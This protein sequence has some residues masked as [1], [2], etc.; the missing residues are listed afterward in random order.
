M[1]ESE[2][3]LGRYFPLPDGEVALLLPDRKLTEGRGKLPKVS[4]KFRMVSGTLGEGTLLRWISLRDPYS[5]QAVK[6][7]KLII[8]YIMCG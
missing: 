2:F 8:I 7:K 3:L 4:G 5:L 1:A 6:K